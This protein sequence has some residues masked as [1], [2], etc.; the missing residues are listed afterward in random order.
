MQMIDV[1]K[2]LAELDS[3]NPN[4]IKESASLEECGPM[5]M[6]DSMGGM[7]K[8]S[9]P[10]SMNITAGSGDELAN[11]L[12]TIMQLA[13]VKQDAPGEM[14]DG[15]GV[16]IMTAEPDVK[17]EPMSGGDAMRSMI[18]K[19]NPMDDEGGDDVS[20]AHGDIDNDGDHDMAD[21]EKEKDDEKETDESWDNSPD[22]KTEG[23]GAFAAHGDMDKNPAGGGNIPKDQDSRSRI[24]SQPTAT[25]ESL[26]DEYKRFI[27]E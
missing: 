27:G 18:D 6:M 3:T 1:M 23:P 20:K 19:L 24:R 21:H 2:R 26:M 13:G 11:M 4:V 12:A 15:S 7:E 17:V 22:T 16:E 9:T 8:P 25:Y 10:A 14:G 5:G